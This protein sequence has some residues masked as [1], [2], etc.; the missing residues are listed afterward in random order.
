MLGAFAAG[1]EQIEWLSRAF[2][3]SYIDRDTA[4]L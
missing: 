2:S 4:R 3:V 1:Q